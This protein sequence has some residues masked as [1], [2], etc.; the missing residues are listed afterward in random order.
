MLMLTRSFAFVSVAIALG[1]AT[2]NPAPTPPPTNDVNATA[3]VSDEERAAFERARP[4]FEAYCMKCH[5]T[6]GAKTSGKA[7]HHISMDAYPFTGH[8][9][10]EAGSA[11]REALTGSEPTMPKDNPGTLNPEELA[12][13]LAWADAFDHAHPKAPHDEGAEHGEH[14]HGEHDEHGGHDDHE[15]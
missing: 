5:T 6:S 10:G 3:V 12:L 4:V 2:T 1:C 15:H 11:V 13:V 8:H 14:E 7:M 9:A